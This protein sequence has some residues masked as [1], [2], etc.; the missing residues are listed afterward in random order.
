MSSSLVSATA[1]IS[2]ARYCSALPTRSAGISSNSYDGAHGHV[3]LGASPGQ[4]YGLH[5]EQVNNADEVALS[6]DGQLQNQ[7]AVRRGGR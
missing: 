4:A 1:S 3:T 6:A 7:R 2:S 5:F